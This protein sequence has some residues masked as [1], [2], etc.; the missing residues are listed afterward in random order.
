LYP[1]AYTH[2][3]RLKTEGLAWAT[4]WYTGISCTSI[5]T[6][7]GRLR[8]PAKRFGFQFLPIKCEIGAVEE[9]FPAKMEFLNSAKSQTGNRYDSGK[10]CDGFGRHTERVHSCRTQQTSASAIA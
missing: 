6:V 1:F 7:N 4:V 5:Q 8:L 3:G 9:Q 2:S 10:C